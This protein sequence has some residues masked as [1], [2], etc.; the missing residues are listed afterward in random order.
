MHDRQRQLKRAS[1]VGERTY[2]VEAR[3]VNLRMTKG[4]KCVEDGSTFVKVTGADLFF[5]FATEGHGT[6]DN[7]ELSFGRHCDVGLSAVI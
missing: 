2:T 5:A 4:L 1:C 7:R 3:S 6:E